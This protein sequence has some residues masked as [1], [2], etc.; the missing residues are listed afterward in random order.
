[1]TT[2][3]CKSR[4][5]LYFQGGHVPLNLFIFCIHFRLLYWL[6]WYSVTADKR[7]GTLSLSLVKLYSKLKRCPSVVSEMTFHLLLLLS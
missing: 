3:V 5:P 2:Q 6:Y 4:D 1:M 7:Y